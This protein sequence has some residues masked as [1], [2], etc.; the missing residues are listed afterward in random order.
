[1]SQPDV[2]PKAVF[3]SDLGAVFGPKMNRKHIRA[4]K[5]IARREIIR[6]IPKYVD[7]SVL[8][9]DPTLFQVCNLVLSVLK[10]CR[11]LQG[12]DLDWI[13]TE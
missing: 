11:A 2:D 5:S 4:I 10:R 8:G 13:N 6:K 7:T 1:M 9:D 12:V 3:G